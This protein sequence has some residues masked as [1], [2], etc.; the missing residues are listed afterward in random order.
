MSLRCLAVAESIRDNL[1][2]EISAN[3]GGKMGPAVTPTGYGT[4]IVPTG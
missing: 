3:G 1:T 4:S 2:P